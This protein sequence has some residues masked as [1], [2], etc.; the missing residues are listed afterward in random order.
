M[1][2]T[3]A[4]FVTSPVAPATSPQNHTSRSIVTEYVSYVRV[5]FLCVHA[6]LI[7]GHTKSSTR[8]LPREGVERPMRTQRSWVRHIHVVDPIARRRCVGERHRGFRWSR[9]ACA[10]H[11]AD[12]A[13]AVAG[14]ALAR[15]RSRDRR[16]REGE[17]DGRGRGRTRGR[18]RVIDRVIVVLF[19][20]V[21]YTAKR[22]V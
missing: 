14:T 2:T 3:R 21:R 22:L 17:G 19:N 7:P 1:T 5:W 8:N 4:R 11:G 20:T 16:A 12:P 9:T 18:A 15:A 13:V 10:D 6:H